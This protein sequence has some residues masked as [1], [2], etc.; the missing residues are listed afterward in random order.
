VPK[1]KKRKIVLKPPNL[2]Q[3]WVVEREVTN[4]KGTHKHRIYVFADRWFDVRDCGGMKLRTN[5]N[6]ALLFISAVMVPVD[7]EDH[8]VF[9][10]TYSGSSPNIEKKILD[11]TRQPWLKH[12]SSET[13]PAPEA[14]PSESTS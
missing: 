8:Q 14:P 11:I 1:N 12:L 13:L 2:P 3:L 4:D 7:F 5:G 10:I 9:L 6:Y